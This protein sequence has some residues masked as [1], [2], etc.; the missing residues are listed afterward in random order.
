MS[1]TE[2]LKCECK[3]CGNHLEFPASAARTTVACPH[4]GQWTELLVPEVTAPSGTV[5]TN[6]GLAAS[7]ACVVLLL[8][9]LGAIA[10]W[11][12]SRV[13]APSH[14]VETNAPAKKVVKEK[15]KATQPPANEA[16]NLPV[17]PVKI[18][19]PKEKSPAD[20]QAGEVTLEKTKGSSLVYATGTL[21]NDSDYQRF[22]VK[23]EFDLFNAKGKKIAATQDYKDILEP[24]Q[25]SVSRADS[26]Q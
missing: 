13:P 25:T 18:A 8:G 19:P 9:V 21:K 15:S 12:G 16:T 10:F 14:S 5:R 17:P 6:L 4:C 7:I 1:N 22:G 11:V 3:E 26:G 20:L 24:H 23:I 2:Y